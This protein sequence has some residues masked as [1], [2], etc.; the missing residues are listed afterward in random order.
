MAPL[1][2]GIQHSVDGALGYALACSVSC[3]LC[4]LPEIRDR[5]RF[6]AEKIEGLQNQLSGFRMGMC[7]FH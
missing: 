3:L 4:K 5:L 2:F 7:F 6:Y 1:L